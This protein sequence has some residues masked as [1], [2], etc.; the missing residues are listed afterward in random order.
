[1]TMTT[2]KRLSHIPALVV[3]Q[4][5]AQGLVHHRAPW[6][7]VEAHRDRRF[8]IFLEGEIP[9]LVSV[10]GWDGGYCTVRWALWPTSFDV[11]F[12]SICEF[13]D[14]PG[15]AWGITT[16]CRYYG[17]DIKGLEVIHCRKA[18]RNR[19]ISVRDY[20]PDLERH[21]AEC[22][23]EQDERVRK[24]MAERAGQ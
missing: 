1:M 10:I 9:A 7:P 22:K 5:C 4:A 23:A 21:F 15:D 16:V 6:F 24:V 20:R 19:L 2:N 12:P 8:E 13:N 3:L 14:W 17:L 18:R 11:D